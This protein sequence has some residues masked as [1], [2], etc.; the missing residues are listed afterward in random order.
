MIL[1]TPDIAAEQRMSARLLRARWLVG[2]GRSYAAVPDLE[3][4]VASNRN[5]AD[6]QA[7]ARDLLADL[8]ANSDEDQT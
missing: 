7:A 2:A 4:I 6:V 8:Q 5:F 1:A 3:A